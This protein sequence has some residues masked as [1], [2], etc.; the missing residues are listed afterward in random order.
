MSRHDPLFSE[1][2]ELMNEL[3]GGHNNKMASFLGFL[4]EN[5]IT[6]GAQTS[7]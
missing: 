7:P 1:E 5:Q 6:S 2:G 3:L 4:D